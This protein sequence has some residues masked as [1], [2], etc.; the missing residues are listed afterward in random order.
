MGTL[1]D[2]AIK[3]AG[4]SGIA[5]RAL[6]GDLTSEDHALLATADTLVLSAIADRVRAKFHGDV[7]R[8]VATRGVLPADVDALVVT[9]AERVNVNAAGAAAPTGEEVL[10]SIALSRLKTPGPRA[11]AVSWDHIGL[12]LAQT[13]LLFGA[14]VLFGGIGNPRQGSRGEAQ[15]G[16]LPLADNPGI[17]RQEITGL[18]QRALREPQWFETAQAQLESRS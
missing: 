14:N 5:Q 1:V 13:A 8:L 9:D 2:I 7:V 17:R 16:V 12:Q 6:D 4:F 3:E 10:R 18:V 15:K 11:V